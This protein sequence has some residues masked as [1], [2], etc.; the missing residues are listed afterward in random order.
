MRKYI[1]LISFLFSSFFISCQKYLDVKKNSN[2]GQVETAADCQL[3]LDDYN[4]MNVGYPSDG[5]TSSDDYYLIDQDYNNSQVSPEDR[6][7]YIWSAGAIRPSASSQWQKPYYAVYY[8]NLVLECL[9]KLNKGGTDQ[10]TLNNLRGSALFYRAYA[11]WQIAQL[12]TH[13]YSEATASQYPG[14]P[15]RLTS[16][17]NDKSDRGTVADTYN[18][19][20]QDLTEA[21]SLMPPTSTVP[22]R[23]N[24][25]AA[26]AMLARTYLSMSDYN[27]ALKNA[28]AALSLNHTLVDFN[29][30]DASY[31][32]PFDPKFNAEIIFHTVTT[33]DDQPLNNYRAKINND[34]V[35]SYQDNDLRKGILIKSNG[36][37]TY[38]FIGNYD[39]AYTTILFDGIA[40]DEMYLTRAE[41]YARAGQ[42][43][44]AMSDLNTLLKTRWA[45]GTY[46]DKTASSADDAL[47]VI[48]SER[49]KELVMRGMRWTDLRRLNQD[50]KF[51]VTLTRTILGQTY[52]LPPN[53]PRYTLLIPTEVI[54]NGHI[55]QNTH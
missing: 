27:N 14:I 41:C 9:D 32:M 17:I 3:L 20:I 49:R 33:D 47:S 6:V 40:V 19:I 7:F 28:D 50:P 11:F 1:Y 25:T 36:D 16:D 45:T 29:T 2:Y 37:S 38:R 5:E 31:N 22:T 43:D 8:A 46:V 53:D 18:K 13:P 4:V 54:L 35:V 55:P 39:A 10:A 21:V 15:L 42:T 48:L 44:L 34:L 26:Y 52:T 51:A 23:P 30:L 24:K 12:Y